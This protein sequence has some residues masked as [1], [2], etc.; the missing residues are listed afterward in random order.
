MG[1]AQRKC[2]T[3]KKVYQV[4]EVSDEMEA[5]F[6]KHYC[7][8]NTYMGIRSCNIEKDIFFHIAALAQIHI[9]CTV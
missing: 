1:L 2:M 7:V 4:K 5:G 3:G 9:E 8:C 6:I